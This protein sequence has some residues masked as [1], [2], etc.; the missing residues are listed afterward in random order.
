LKSILN[1]CL[2][3]HHQEG[4]LHRIRLFT[5][6]AIGE[7]L[8]E[9]ENVCVGGIA[10]IWGPIHT[11]PDAYEGEQRLPTMPSEQESSDATP[12]SLLHCAAAEQGIGC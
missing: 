2:S 7:Q 4:D 11:P 12:P 6:A 3:Y 9:W 8:T 10:E 1:F 5:Q